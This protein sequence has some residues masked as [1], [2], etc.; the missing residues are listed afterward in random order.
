MLIGIKTDIIEI[1]VFT[2]GAN[3]FLGI[4]GSG[5]AR[6]NGA[7]PFTEIGLAFTEKNGDELIH[8]RVGEEKVWGIWEE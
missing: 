4:G 5:I 8:A 2:A 7:G 6:G 1:V 3:A